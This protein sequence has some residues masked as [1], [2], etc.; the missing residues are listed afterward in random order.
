M[1]SHQTFS[2][3]IKHLSSQIKFGQA[4]L[5]YIINGEVIEFAK[6]KSMSRQVSVLIISTVLTTET[7]LYSEKG[8]IPEK[9]GTHLHTYI[10]YSTK[11][12]QVKIWQTECHLPKLYPVKSF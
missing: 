7:G 1:A 9:Y 4:N 10:P 2:N 12:L 8:F 6:D 3:Q 11:F 5:L